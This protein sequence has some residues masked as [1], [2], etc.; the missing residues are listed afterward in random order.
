MLQAGARR[1][2]LYDIFSVFVPGAALILAFVPLLP[3]FI[4]LSSPP[5]LIPFLI[6]SFIAG[7][8]IH[9]VAIKIETFAER[10]SHRE[11][12]REEVCSPNHVDTDVV[13]RFC[14]EAAEVFDEI[15]LDGL[16]DGTLDAAN[17]DQAETL[18]VLV[19]SYIHL[20]GRGR[21]RTFQALYSFHRSMWVITA[22]IGLIYYLYAIISVAGYWETVDLYQSYIGSVN[23]APELIAMGGAVIYL[24]GWE[25]FSKA[26]PEYQKYFIQYLISDFLVLQTADSPEDNK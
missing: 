14:K 20:D 25:A 16:E 1:F 11:V 18:Y 22:P 17:E 8:A 23:I 10:E 2:E 4:P 21:S 15:G 13:K 5:I 3:A 26:R 7:R 24:T 19:R 9:V 12:F 6:A